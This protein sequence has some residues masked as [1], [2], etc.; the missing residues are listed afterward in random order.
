MERLKSDFWCGKK[1]H[2]TPEEIFRIGDEL[3]ELA[4]RLRPDWPSEEERQED[5]EV[6]VRVAAALRSVR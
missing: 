5:L 3:R 4:R 6:H 1:K 2:L